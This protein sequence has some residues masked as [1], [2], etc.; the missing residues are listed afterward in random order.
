MVNLNLPQE[1]LDKLKWM[2]NNPENTFCFLGFTLNLITG[3]L[4]DVLQQ[5]VASPQVKDGTMYQLITELLIKYASTSKPV[6][7]GKLVNFKDFSGGYAYEN[8]F[9]RRVVE[10]IVKIFGKNPQNLIKTAK[11]I[12]GKQIEY[13]DCSIEIE[14]FPEISMTIILWT[15]E[16]LPPTANVLFDE[17]SGKT[18]NAEDIAWLSDLTLWRLSLAQTLMS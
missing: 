1:T 13:G 8:A 9:H 2:I 4:Q 14:T 17:S 3:D 18:F 11:L 10:P 5:N 16:E 6:K 12:G 15:D 7:V